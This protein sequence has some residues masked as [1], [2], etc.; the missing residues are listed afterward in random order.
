M[1]LR[2]FE[3]RLERLVEGMFAKAF[4]SGLQPVEVGRRLVKT[5]DANPTLDTK[6][7]QI[8]PNEFVVRLASEDYER[9]TQLE[10]SLIA[11]LITTVRQHAE[12]ED[13]LFRGRVAV[14]LEEDPELSVG[15]F[16]VDARFN[17]TTADVLPAYLE[18]PDG[19]RVELGPRVLRI[20]RMTDCDVVLADPNASRYHAELHPA[21]DAYELV[22]LGS[23]NGSRVNGERVSRRVLL[24]GDQLR[25]GTITLKFR[26][27]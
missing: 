14:S 8:V 10:D 18:L 21:G 15:I 17:D 5:L 26:L 24:D 6:G 16:R 22:D 3:A 25:F 2:N 9:F 12:D 20:G 11:E 1:V 19:Q 4:R 13:L 23:T 7:R 27:A